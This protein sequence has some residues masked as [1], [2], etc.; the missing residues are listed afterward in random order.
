MKPVSKIWM[1][2]NLV[3]WNDAKIHVLSHIVH[4]GFGVFEGIRCYETEGGGRAIFRLKDHIRRLEESAHILRLS[5]PFKSEIWMDACEQVIRVNG[6]KSAYI[7]PTLCVGYG[8]M[9]LAA[10]DNPPVAAVAAFEWG[11]YLGDDAA[12]LGIRAKVSSYA[13]SHVNTHMLKGKINGMYVNNIMAKREAVDDGYQ[14]AIML[15]PSG[16]VA[17][18]S[19]ENIFLVRDGEV[20]TPPITMVLAGITR[21]SV[22][23]ILKEMGFVVAERLIT[24]DELYIADEVFVT[25]TAAEITP[26]CEVD[27]RKVGTG[28]PGEITAEVQRRFAKAV[29]GGDP[30][31]AKKWLHPVR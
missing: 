4:Y 15:D 26:I 16:Y 7:R 20:F 6:L 28:K 2:G 17:E 31:F 10:I 11:A 23:K 3:D 22:I 13:R 5:N 1:N 30:T 24:R 8:K 29:R 25:G 12:K 21:D 14:E 27:N 19:G 18:G 9:G